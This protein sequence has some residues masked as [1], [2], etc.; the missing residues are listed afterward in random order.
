VLYSRHVFNLVKIRHVYFS[1][2]NL[3]ISKVQIL[4]V[5]YSFGTDFLQ[6]VLFSSVTALYLDYKYLSKIS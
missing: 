6:L 4:S 1:A 2:A 3:V 5:T